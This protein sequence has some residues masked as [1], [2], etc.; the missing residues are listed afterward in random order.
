MPL[1]AR[2]KGL[3]M[4]FIC[5]GIVLFIVGV[6][7]LTKILLFQKSVEVIP[8]VLRFEYQSNYGMAWGFLGDVKGAT[9]ALTIFSVIAVGLLIFAFIKWR[10]SMPRFMQLSLALVISGAVG[11]LID[12]VFI[13]YVRDFIQTEFISFPT[14]NVADAAITIGGVLLAAALLFTSS[15]SHFFDSIFEKKKG[16]KHGGTAEAENETDS[17]KDG[18]VD[19]SADSDGGAGDDGESC[20]DADESTQNDVKPVQAADADNGSD[21]DGN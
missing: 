20:A 17:D 5:L 19:G 16:G 10:K 1:R 3:E 11:N 14:F 2:L 18:D 7:Q 12:R 9:I 8:G 21:S 15:G 4:L 6:D 13:G